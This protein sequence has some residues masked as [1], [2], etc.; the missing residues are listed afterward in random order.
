MA[1]ATEEMADGSPDDED[2]EAWVAY[3]KAER[4]MVGGR[5]RGGPNKNWGKVRGGGKKLNGANPNASKR[6]RCYL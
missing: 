4:G 6:N 3:R 2:C 1:T 5:K